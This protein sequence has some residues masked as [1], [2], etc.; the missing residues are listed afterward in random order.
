MI[1]MRMFVLLVTGTVQD[2]KFALEHNTCSE[3][4]YEGLI[5]VF[6]N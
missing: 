2:H 6:Y 1:F 5:Y 4:R 3:T